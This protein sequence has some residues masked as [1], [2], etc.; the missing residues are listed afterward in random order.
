MRKTYML[1]IGDLN[2][3]K[4]IKETDIA[5]TLSNGEE[6][7]FLHFNQTPNKL[8]LGEEVEAFLYFDQKKRLCATL[9]KPLIT[10]NQPAF[11]KVVALNEAGLFVDMGI[12]KDLLVSK[13]YL[14][15]A[16]KL[17]PRVGE[18]IPV[19]LKV[20]ANQLVGQIINE[21]L[22]NNPSLFQL[23]N[24]V[25]ATISAIYPNGIVAV[26][27]SFGVGFIPKALTRGTHH[28]G[29]IIT[30]TVKEL[31]EKQVIG[32]MIKNK[33]VERLSDSDIILSYLRKMGGAVNLGNHAQPEEIDKVF[34]MSKSAYK[35]AIGHLYKLHLITITDDYI[36]LVE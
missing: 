27:P 13:D 28:L 5:Y 17:W 30:F 35:R 20:K 15:N 36:Q 8:V 33:E 29:E 12:S 23:N 6:D 3:L 14:P 24:E 9:E 19:L 22:T 34:H 26:T 16:T 7:V 25:E 1:K 18:A 2:H 10:I 31:K 32:T 11:L 4:V 21:P